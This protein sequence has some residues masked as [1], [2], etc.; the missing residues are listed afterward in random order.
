MKTFTVVKTVVRTYSCQV[1]AESM[2]E[3]AASAVYQ[4]PLSK[5]SAARSETTTA[6]AADG[7]VISVRPETQPLIALRAV[8]G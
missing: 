8:E 7:A 6:L 3:A 4:V 5:W 1:S 2:E